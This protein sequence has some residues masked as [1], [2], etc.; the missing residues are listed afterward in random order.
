M[1]ARGLLYRVIHTDQ[2]GDEEE[3]VLVGLVIWDHSC[4]RFRLAIAL[5]D[6]PVCCHGR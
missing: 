6:P 5:A 3:D 2:I 4:G 1:F